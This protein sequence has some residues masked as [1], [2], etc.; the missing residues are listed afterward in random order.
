MRA[1]GTG[2]VGAKKKTRGGGRRSAGYQSCAPPDRA[3]W[4]AKSK[5]KKKRGGGRRRAG[6]QSA[7]HR[8]MPGGGEEEVEDRAGGPSPL[9]A[10]RSPEPGSPSARV[11][12]YAEAAPAARPAASGPPVR[13]LSEAAARHT[14]KTLC[15]PRPRTRASKCCSGR[16]SDQV[17][18]GNGSK[19]RLIV[20]A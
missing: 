1:T 16:F 11:S 17:E 6:D 8:D 14:G 3:R 12:Q 2:P 18:Q 4:V 10:H 9:N 15:R 19:H 20:H 5:K 13:I 7:L